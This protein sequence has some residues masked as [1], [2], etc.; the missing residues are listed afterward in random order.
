MVRGGGV[1]NLAEVLVAALIA[2]MVVV[3]AGSTAADLRRRL[4]VKAT[5]TGGG[6]GGFL[7]RGGGPELY[8]GGLLGVSARVLLCRESERARITLSGLPI[9]GTVSGSARF[10][11]G[12]GEDPIVVGEPLAGTLRRRFVKIV[13]ARHD[14]RSD[15][16]VVVARL[17]LVLGTQTVTLQRYVA[18]DGRVRVEEDGDAC[19]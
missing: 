16:V 10:G 2:Q 14:E 7:R 18:R 6:G 19:A 12:V 3:C 5:T 17:P 1:A 9:G 15:T 8:V 11:R 4:A 13:E